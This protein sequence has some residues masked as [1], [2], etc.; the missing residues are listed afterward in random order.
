MHVVFVLKP[1]SPDGIECCTVRIESR[2]II[3]TESDLCL[4]FYMIRVGVWVCD[5]SEWSRVTAHFS[6]PQ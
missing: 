3:Q 6:Q 5:K 2:E 1:G 4:V